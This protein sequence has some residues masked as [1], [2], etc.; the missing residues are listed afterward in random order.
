MPADPAHPAEG[1]YGVRYAE[2]SFDYPSPALAESWSQSTQ[3]LDAV[4]DA[5][6]STEADSADEEQRTDR[7]HARETIWWGQMAG[8][9]RAALMVVATLL[10]MGG[11]GL[12]LS[13]VSSTVSSDPAPRAGPPRSPSLSRRPHQPCPRRPRPP[14]RPLRAVR[15]GA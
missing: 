12:S 4:P 8:R 13:M 15:A 7:G 6:L 14:R 3:P 5:G 2:D 10:V 11:F 9:R 1:G